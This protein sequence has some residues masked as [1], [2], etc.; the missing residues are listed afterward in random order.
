MGLVLAG[1]LLIVV[2]GSTTWFLA[3][4]ERRV[5]RIPVGESA[6]AR[7]NELLAAERLLARLGIPVESVTGRERLW[8][9]PPS[10]DTLVVLGLGPMSAE[11]R[12]RLRHWLERGGRLLVEA[13]E[14]SEGGRIPDDFLGDLGIRLRVEEE[15]RLAALDEDRVTARIQIPDVE[16]PPSLGFQARYYLEPEGSHPGDIQAGDRTRLARR[17]IGQGRLTVISDSRFMTNARIGELDHAFLTAWLTR[18]DGAGKVWL[19][20]DTAMP[21]LGALLWSRAPEALISAL[22]LLLVWLWS[23]G[24]RLG[25]LIGPPEGRRRDL[26]EHLDAS[27]DFLWRHGH[28]GQLVET[29]RRHLLNDWS[30]RHPEIAQAAPRVQAERIAA[31]TSQ[32]VE[33]LARALFTQSGDAQGFIAQAI[34]LQA[35]WPSHG[36]GGR[37]PDRARAPRRPG[38]DRL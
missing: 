29:N 23:L 17:D 9:L 21:G 34:R 28:A 24:G 18:P 25:P 5:E 11:R 37:R 2:A 19:L 8:N 15:E 26:I 32:P 27:A 20:H 1:L 31:L 36:A 13:M 16:S 22:L 35:S 38:S 3:N 6:K 10:T 7:S 30:I 33:A 4:F 12:V 14:A